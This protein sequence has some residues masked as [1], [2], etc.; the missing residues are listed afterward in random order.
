[1]YHKDFN[2][3]FRRAYLEFEQINVTSGYVAQVLCVIL[4]VF[5]A[6]MFITAYIYWD[7]FVQEPNG[8]YQYSKL[9]RFTLARDITIS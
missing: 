5:K 9:I 6:A 2:Q 4:A 1:M 3:R 7:K 8:S